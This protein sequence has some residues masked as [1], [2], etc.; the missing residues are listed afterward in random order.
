MSLPRWLALDVLGEAW[1]KG[2]AS[3][4][5]V[6]K[7]RKALEAEK[8]RTGSMFLAVSAGLVAC[9]LKNLAQR[10]DEMLD[11]NVLRCSKGGENGWDYVDPK[12][13]RKAGI[14]EVDLQHVRSLE[15][16]A[17]AKPARSRR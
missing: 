6:P 10:L 4:T 17:A 9:G 16:A 12:A 8:R 11:V 2:Y 1:V 13:A 7:F 15:R 5:L 3:A 14:L